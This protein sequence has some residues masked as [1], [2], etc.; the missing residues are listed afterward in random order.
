MQELTIGCFNQEIAAVGG[1]N[2]NAKV[3]RKTSKKEKEREN[4]MNI[5]ISSSKGRKGKRAFPVTNIQMRRDRSHKPQRVEPLVKEEGEMSGNEEV[6]EQ[7]R[8][9][10]WMEWCEDVM[11]TEIKTL[12]RLHR[13]QTTS[14]DLPKEKVHIV[15]SKLI[16]SF[17]LVTT[18]LLV[19]CR[20]N[21]FIGGVFFFRCFQRFGSICSFLDEG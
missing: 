12:A 15:V 16:L 8:E 9:V 20:T 10:K 5:S 11:K 13:L 4:L 2:T 7:F 19:Y 14:A 17:V 21:I 3:G 6:Y 18:V 1:K